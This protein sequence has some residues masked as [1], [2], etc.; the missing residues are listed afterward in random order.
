MNIQNNAASYDAAYTNLNST[1]TDIFTKKLEERVQKV[2]ET[3]KAAEDKF[4]EKRED[5]RL[6]D[7][8]L[9]EQVYSRKASFE[10]GRDLVGY[11]LDLYA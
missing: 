1:A 2:Q 9:E 10:N 3:E 8:Q 11:N 7:K 6:R 4:Q 5:D